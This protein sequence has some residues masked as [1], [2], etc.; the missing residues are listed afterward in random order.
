MSAHGTDTVDCSYFAERRPSALVV[1]HERSGTHF[2]MNS[3][4]ACYGHV[5]QP[6]IN[7][8]RPDVNINYFHPPA[9][10]RYLLSLTKRPMANVV[11]SH[12]PAEFFG[13]EFTNLTRRYAILAICRN[14]VSVMIS[15][16]RYLHRW[17]WFEGPKTFDAL[18]LARE[19]PCGRMLRYQTRQY[20]SMLKRWAAHVD[21]WLTAA[22][23]QPGVVMVRYEDLDARYEELM[24]ALS[25]LF[26]RP[27]AG[28]A[29]PSRQE[30]VIEGG[31]QNPTGS[32]PPDL[33]ALERLCRD[34]VGATMERLG[35]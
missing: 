28:F 6:W 9:I 21:G 3:L 22:E 33:E 1:S 35:Y 12:H 31:P 2:L 27:P 11:K 25:P 30:N 19:E 29:R 24:Q 34:E 26:G 4:A 8:D 14:P 18:T 15:L 7:F 20:S 17:Q 23:S 5:A 16:W 13:G 10:S 32:G